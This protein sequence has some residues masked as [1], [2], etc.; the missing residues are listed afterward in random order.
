MGKNEDSLNGI[1]TSYVVEQCHVCGHSNLRSILFLGYLPPVNT[2]NSIGTRPSE[3]SGYPAEWLQCSKCKLVQIGLVVDPRILFPPEYPYTSSTTKILR[4]NFADMYRECMTLMELGSEDLVVDIGSNDGNLLSNFQKD[5]KVLG[6]TPEEIG[7]IAIQR[8]IPTIISYFGREVVKSILEEHG[9]AKVV[10]A[11][12][13]FAHI[14]GINEIVECILELLDQD[15]V[16][17]TECHYLGSLVETLQYDTIYHEHLMYYSLHSLKYLLE[18]HGLE[19]FHAKKIPTHGGSIRAYVSRKGKFPVKSSVVEILDE[20]EKIE[21]EG[22]GLLDFKNRVVVS[23]LELHSMLL[24]IKKQNKKVYGIGAPSR[25]STLINYVGIDD[26]IMDCVLEI[27]GSHKIGKYIP[28]TLIPV[29]EESKLYEDQ[30]EYA[31]LLSWHIADELAPKIAQNGFKGDFI[32][33]L[34]TPRI[35]KNPLLT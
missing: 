5:H 26:G 33:P 4:E 19:V 13:V 14:D 18:K 24:D 23:K 17:I 31:L 1:G 6:V 28:G 27:K 10:T 35:L 11:T 2:M 9:S 12:N 15:G 30:P 8:G 20:E 3:Q 29:I 34:P 16:F 21:L 22:K 25:A 7:K 32:V